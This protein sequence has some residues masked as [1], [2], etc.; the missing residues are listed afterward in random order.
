MLSGEKKLALTTVITVLE[1]MRAKGLI[2]RR[3]QAGQSFEY[4]AALTRLEHADSSIHTVLDN[5]GDRTAVLLRLAGSLTESD[6]SVLRDALDRM[7]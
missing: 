2:Q 1:R 7:Q 5:A 6:R 4:F 3:A